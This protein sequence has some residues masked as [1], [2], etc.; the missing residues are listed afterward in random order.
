[1][2]G[3]PN[4]TVAGSPGSSIPSQSGFANHIFLMWRRQDFCKLRD[5]SRA[6]SMPHASS[7]GHRVRVP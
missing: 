5:G 3:S 1:M 4:R 7:H 6:A 2:A